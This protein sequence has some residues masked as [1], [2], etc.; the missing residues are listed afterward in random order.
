[1]AAEVAAAAAWR[2]R[3]AWRRRRQLGGSA[4]LGVAGA[5]L[6]MRRQCGGGGSNNGVLAAAG[7]CVLMTILIIT[8]TMMIDYWLFFRAG[9][10]GRGG[11]RAGCM[12]HWR[13]LQWT[14]MTIAMVIVWAKKRLNKEKG[15]KELK[16]GLF[17]SCCLILLLL[18]CL[19]FS[20]QVNQFLPLSLR[21]ADTI[22]VKK[23]LFN[24]ITFFYIL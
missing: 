12:H 6:D 1:V 8:M 18:F 16:D 15:E 4:I 2:R 19:S 23:R 17:F 3:P 13:S 14:V 24:S 5:R 9:E 7:W 22:T 11:E 21:A 10:G 20:M